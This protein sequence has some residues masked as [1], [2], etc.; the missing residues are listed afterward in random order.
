MLVYGGTQA[1]M[2][3]LLDT[4]NEIN[5]Q[6]GIITDYQISNFADIVDA[7]HVVQTEIGITGTTAAEA[8]ETIQGSISAMKSAW[9]NLITGLANPDADMSVLVDNFVESFEIAFEN[10]Q[11]AIET[12]L[13]SSGDV[14]ARMAPTSLDKLPD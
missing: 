1:E 13:M 10:V 3:R 8:A 12:A 2:L 11:P 9:R 7:I 4:A 5:A 6:Q 14:I